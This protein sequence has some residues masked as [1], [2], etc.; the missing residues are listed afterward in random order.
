[1]VYLPDPILSNYEGEARK[2]S[3]FLSWCAALSAS[4]AGFPRHPAPRFNLEEIFNGEAERGENAKGAGD[5]ELE[6]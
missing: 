2:D 6:Y 1:M 4:R 5:H 3:S